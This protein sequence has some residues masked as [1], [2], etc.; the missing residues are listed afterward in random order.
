MLMIRCIKACRL[1]VKQWCFTLQ[2]GVSLHWWWPAMHALMHRHR[3]S[4][5]PASPLSHAS[6][7]NNTPFALRLIFAARVSRGSAVRVAANAAGTPVPKNSILVIGATGTLGRQVSQLAAWQVSKGRR[8][9]WMR[10]SRRCR[11][12]VRCLAVAARL[13]WPACSCSHA[14]KRSSVCEE[15]LAQYAL[16]CYLVM[17]CP[18]CAR[19]SMQ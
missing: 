8:W 10:N 12:T 7:F 1:T 15:M 18:C 19:G 5:P 4:L 2:Y 9:R 11:T 13:C 14:C 6:A 16:L 3:P 17:L